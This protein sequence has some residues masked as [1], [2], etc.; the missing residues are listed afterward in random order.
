M[1][2]R[3]FRVIFIIV[4]VALLG[5]SCIV[6]DVPSVDEKVSVNQ[7][8]PLTF[9]YPEPINKTI[10][11]IDYLQSTAPVGNFGGEFIASTI[12]QGPKTFNPFNCKDNISQTNLD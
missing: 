1:Y 9:T 11:G 10:N 4:I 2:Q 3:V 5:K 7:N 12:G 6:K 8:T